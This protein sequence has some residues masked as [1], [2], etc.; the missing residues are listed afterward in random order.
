MSVGVHCALV[1]FSGNAQ[2]P[3]HQTKHYINLWNY[4]YIII[5]WDQNNCCL[6]YNVYFIPTQFFLF[7]LKKPFCF[8][9]P[10]YY[11]KY[12]GYAYFKQT[13]GKL[14]YFQHYRAIHMS[15]SVASNY[16][17]CII[18]SS[19]KIKSIIIVVGWLCVEFAGRCFGPVC[20]HFPFKIPISNGSITACKASTYTCVTSD[21]RLAKAV[22][23]VVVVVVLQC[24]IFP[25]F[26]S[27][28]FIFPQQ[29]YEQIY[30]QIKQ[31]AI[32]NAIHYVEYFVWN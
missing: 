2:R 22:L 16:R 32:S 27:F 3:R 28:L 23:F 20:S 19:S 11:G 15:I 17:N 9:M 25:Y 26:I 21:H 31:P 13:I 30:W 14:D 1:L 18:A 10:F 24:R 8:S 12:I 29:K 4:I 5:K 7:R 6:F